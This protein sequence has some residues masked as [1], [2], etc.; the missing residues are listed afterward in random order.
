[1]TLL[2]EHV[3]AVR[4]LL[5]GDRVDTTGRYVRLDGVQ[6]DWPPSARPPLLIGARGDRTIRLAGEVADGVLLDSVTDPSTVRRARELVDD[7]RARAG[8]PGR[9]IVTAYTQVDPAQ[10][11][12]ELAAEVAE[13]A[14]V[15]GRA[16]ADTVVLQGTGERPDPR[17]IV[18]AL[19]AAGLVTPRS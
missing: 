2:R 18:E 15:L 14:A 5:D 8:R 17:P 10:A 13:R 12:G 16:G 19:V 9:A 11:A 7:A 1:M 4:D 3:D 6:L